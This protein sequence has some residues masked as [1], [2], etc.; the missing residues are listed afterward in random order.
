MRYVVSSFF[1]AFC[2]GLAQAA[3]FKLTSPSLH[4]GG[5]LPMAQVQC[6]GDN[7]SPELHWENAPAGT[8]SFALTVYDPDAPTGSGWWHWQIYNIPH[9]VN[10]LSADAGNAAHPQIPLGSVQNTNDGGTLGFMGACPPKGDKPHRYIFTVFAL[11]VDKI[12]VPEHAS[13][14]AV[15]FNLN[16]NVLGKATLTVNYGR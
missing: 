10:S 5:T 15:G 9:G 3:E 16:K 12:K 2:C 8:K 4:E 14:A 1:L 13:N 7:L 6:G 11:G